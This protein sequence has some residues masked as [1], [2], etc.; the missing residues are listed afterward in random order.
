M[1]GERLHLSNHTVEN[2]IRNA[3]EKLHA[4]RRLE[5][6]LTAQRLGLVQGAAPDPPR[7]LDMNL[8]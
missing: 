1:I 5:L 2:H 3:R 6:V 8:S 4:A 7:K